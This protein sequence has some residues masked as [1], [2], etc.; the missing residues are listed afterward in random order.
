MVEAIILTIIIS[1]LINFL[2]ISYLNPLSLSNKIIIVSITTL[3][4]TYLI[5]NNNNSDK[6]NIIENKFVKYSIILF[7]LY[8]CY[9]VLSYIYGYG[10]KNAKSFKMI[11]FV[12]FLLFI[13]FNLYKY[14]KI[15]SI[16]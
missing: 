13:G 1:F 4:I 15:S 10:I 5:N 6:I 16:K 3:I 2:I 12:V 11:L 14:N 9:Y 7:I 8:C